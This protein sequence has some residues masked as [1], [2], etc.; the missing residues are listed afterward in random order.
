MKYATLLAVLP[1][2]AAAAPVV[3]QIQ[4][5]TFST[6]DDVNG[7]RFDG[8]VT[9]SKIS[10]DS[11]DGVFVGNEES[12]NYSLFKFPDAVYSIHAG[13]GKQA[14]K[15]W[16]PVRCGDNGVCNGCSDESG[17]HTPRPPHS[18]GLFS[19]ILGLFD[20][21]WAFI[22]LGLNLIFGCLYKYPSGGNVWIGH[23]GSQCGVGS[24]GYL[25]YPS[26]PHIGWDNGFGGKYCGSMKGTQFWRW[27]DGSVCPLNIFKGHKRDGCGVTF[28]SHGHKGGPVCNTCQDPNPSWWDSHTWNKRDSI[29][30]LD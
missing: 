19:C 4:E 29:A 22:G 2:L 7:C 8:F 9:G 26:I 16:S 12:T 15:W 28:P 17:S 11:Q 21:C 13:R 25:H 30:S 1:A 23:G 5:R 24:Q 18:F 10:I 14:Y 20:I 6:S 3:E 27:D